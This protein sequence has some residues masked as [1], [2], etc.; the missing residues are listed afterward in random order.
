M[1][2]PWRSIF[3]AA[4]E[5]A[6]R[7]KPQAAH[8][9]TETLRYVAGGSVDG[10]DPSA[11]VAAG[12]STGI[13][14]RL[15][16]CLFSFG[17]KRVGNI[18][19]A[20]ATEIR[21]AFARGYRISRDGLTITIL[22]RPDV[23]W[24]DG[25]SATAR[26]VKWSLDR[27]IALRALALLGH[28]GILTEP[29][30]VRIVDDHT[31]QVTLSRPDR[32]GVAALCAPGVIMI[33]SRLAARHATPGDPWA[34]DW[35]RHNAAGGGAYRLA[36]YRAGDRI[37]LHRNEAW[38]CGAVGQLPY[39]RR[40]IIR[41]VADPATRASLVARGDAD[42]SI[43]LAAGNRHVGAVT[44]V[45]AAARVKVVV[46]PRTN[47]VTLIAMNTRAAPFDNVKVRQAIAAALPRQGL[48]QAALR[49][50]SRYDTEP[51]VTRRPK[52]D[53]SPPI[54]LNTD[55]VR[56]RRLLREAGLPNGFK[57]I[58]S[59][60]AAQAATAEPLAAL[61]QEALG[62]VGIQVEIR[63]QPDREFSPRQAR[64]TLAF[65]TDVATA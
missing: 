30:Q 29:D 25:T 51:T 10:L 2:I 28:A 6:H 13:G 54:P 31:V 7:A 17:R 58:F 56:A 53:G 60:N 16:D 44:N 50:R 55:P 36:Q 19:V 64:T 34:R 27:A 42:L 52:Q 22:L 46:A 49:E 18:W 61:L 26:D 41:M 47:D 63:Q 21:G 59:F 48:F 3:A 37:I 57:T 11:A 14:A 43:D 65:Y 45:A 8:P 23:V 15:Y 1:T 5:R 20:D 35:L 32:F 24:H 40:V 4:S 62:R 33:N 9:Q 12:Q 39:Y 38:T